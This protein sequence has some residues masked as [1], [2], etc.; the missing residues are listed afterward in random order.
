MGG[1]VGSSAEGARLVVFRGEHLGGGARLPL[2]RGAPPAGGSE[3][4][5]C[6][7][8]SLKQKATV[9]TVNVESERGRGACLVALVSRACVRSPRKAVS[10][11]VFVVPHPPGPVLS[12]IGDSEPALGLLSGLFIRN[13]PSSA[14][15]RGCLFITIP[16]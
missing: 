16:V 7:L 13:H 9:R 1:K 2:S 11:R 15:S 3:T 5:A 8:L 6:R 12:R 14:C 10:H 4:H